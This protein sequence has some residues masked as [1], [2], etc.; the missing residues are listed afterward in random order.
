MTMSK[1]IRIL[2]H[3][4]ILVSMALS[5]SLLFHDAAWAATVAC[6][7]NVTVDLL[8]NGVVPQGAAT[9]S[10]LVGPVWPQV[11]PLEMQPGGSTPDGYLYAAFRTGTNRLLVG[12][13]VGSDQDL[14]DQDSVVFIFDADNSNSFTNGDFYIQVK[15]I[16]GATPISSG[17][18]CTQSTGDVT[19]FQFDG[20]WQEVTGSDLAAI[21]AG[22]GYDGLSKNG[23][24][25]AG[26]SA[27]SVEA[28]AIDIGLRQDLSG[29]KKSTVVGIGARLFVPGM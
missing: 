18:A 25:S 12:V 26:L 29:D 13:D 20:S 15:A 22:G 28:G 10:C 21:R 17:T 1:Q 11:A 3:A 24:A 4:R 9:A 14:S 19:Y 2:G 5:A 8:H 7:K 27:I 16:P 6:I 23:Y